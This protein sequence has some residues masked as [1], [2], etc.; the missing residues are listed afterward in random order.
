MIVVKNALLL[1]EYA[2]RAAQEPDAVPRAPKEW[3][4][5]R[6][7]AQTALQ[8]AERTKATKRADLYRELA[9]R[10]LTEARSAIATEQDLFVLVYGQ[11]RA[12]GRTLWTHDCEVLRDAVRRTWYQFDPGEAQDLPSRPGGIEQAATADTR[13]GLP[14][15]AEHGSTAAVSGDAT[16]ARSC[17]PVAGRAVAEEERS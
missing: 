5:Q 7:A 3:P 2:T 6:I 10:I 16:N 12:Q 13:E 11:L 9:E 4:A 1:T 14:S 8:M 15:V 17:S